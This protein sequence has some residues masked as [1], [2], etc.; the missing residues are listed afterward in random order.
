MW[1]YALARNVVKV[2]WWDGLKKY[3]EDGKIIS[4]HNKTK[5]SYKIT[6]EH[7]EFMNALRLKTIKKNDNKF[8]SLVELNNILTKKFKDYKLTP[9]WLGQVHCTK[10]FVF[11][12]ETK[13]FVNNN[14]TR[15]RTR[16]SHF[17]DTRYG[18]PIN[19][20]LRALNQDHQNI[21]SATRE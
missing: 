16:H 12:F 7:I 19:S 4:N 5:V 15:K 1:H 14:I 18:K 13:G 11:W 6:K 9:R 3:S 10:H 20:R 2:H 8:V 17:P 21:V